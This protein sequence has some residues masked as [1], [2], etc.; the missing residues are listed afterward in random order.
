MNVVHRLPL[1]RVN[2]LND[3]I[4][5]HG[6]LIETDRGAILV[7][8]GVGEGNRFIE[9]RFEPVRWRI[10][11]LLAACGL[12]PSDVRTVVN[13]HL[14]FDHCGNNRTFAHAEI[15]VQRA[16][17]EAARQPR[18]TVR[19]WFDHERARIREVEGDL[20]I[21][22]GVTVLASPGHTPGHQSV[23]VETARGPTLIAAQAAWTAREYTLGGD[24]DNQA[25][26]GLEAAYRRSIERLKTFGAARVLFSHDVAEADDSGSRDILP[27]TT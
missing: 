14:H 10:L 15:V 16:E 11:D 27:P 1:A 12:T 21:V 18:Y 9:E 13:S 4:S 7:D 20:E 25:H 23:L 24:P 17:L 2:Y 6:Y 3:R 19:E 8:T 26:E 22:P 5:V